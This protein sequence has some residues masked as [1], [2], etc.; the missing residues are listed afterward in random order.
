MILVSSAL[1]LLDG[2]RNRVLPTSSKVNAPLIV[3]SC[4]VPSFLVDP[5]ALVTT[6][7]SL[8]SLPFATRCEEAGER[9][10]LGF[11]DVDAVTAG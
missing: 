9:R 1:V 11:C 5:V 6:N 4:D 3:Y 10:S 8:S 2:G 7:P